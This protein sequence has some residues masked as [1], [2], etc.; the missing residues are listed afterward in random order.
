MLLAKRARSHAG[1]ERQKTRYSNDPSRSLKGGV[2]RRQL[3]LKLA[4]LP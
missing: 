1:A 4:W 2:N 3:L